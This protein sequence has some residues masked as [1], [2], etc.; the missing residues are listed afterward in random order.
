MQ[1]K[2]LIRTSVSICL[3]LTA[4]TITWWVAGVLPARA[5]NASSAVGEVAL[6]L[7]KYM[8]VMP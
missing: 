4:L 8:L 2:T 1:H 3:V 5:I 7:P 6:G